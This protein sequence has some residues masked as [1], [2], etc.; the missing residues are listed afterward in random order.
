MY[1]RGWVASGVFAKYPLVS[2]PGDN[3]ASVTPAGPLVIITLISLSSD[4]R[5]P[6]NF[7]FLRHGNSF[8]NVRRRFRG[9]RRRADL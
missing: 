6:I 5:N 1:G 7:S 3:W 9:R 8:L 4:Q 2:R